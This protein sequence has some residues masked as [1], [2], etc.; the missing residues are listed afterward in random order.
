MMSDTVSKLSSLCGQARAD[1]LDFVRTLV[2]CDSPPGKESAAAALLESE[3]RRLN[4]DEVTKDEIGNVIGVIKGKSSSE[5]VLLTSHLDCYS[6][7]HDLSLSRDPASSAIDPGYSVGYAAC[8]AKA[9][10][11][12]QLYAGACLKRLLGV[13]SCSLAVCGCVAEMGGLGIGI[14]H[15]LST[16]LPAQGIYP[17]LAL[18]GNPTSLNIR[19]GHDGWIG[20][21]VQVDGNHLS[22]VRGVSL[23]LAK[24]LRKKAVQGTSAGRGE[25]L[26]VDSPQ[27]KEFTDL[28]RGTI[29]VERRL[30][31]ED[32][33]GQV[34]ADVK[35]YVR[36]VASNFGDIWSEVNIDQVRHELV[37]GK[38][39]TIPSIVQPW[40]SDDSDDR[41][42]LLTQSLQTA[43]CNFKT[44]HWDLHRLQ[45]GTS[46]SVLSGQ[47][48]ITC[49]GYGPG[50][51]SSLVGC[52]EEIPSWKMTAATFGNAVMLNAVVGPERDNR[53]SI[54]RKTAVLDP[55]SDTHR[56]GG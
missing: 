21:I 47:Y 22:Q 52:D 43:D 53:E 35:A 38:S 44:G 50:D 32:S 30:N 45:A 17:K 23:A 33:I 56:I 34:I 10:L 12:A 42:R 9:G 18:I 55:R 6:P 19:L 40:A 15:L 24:R 20:L 14:R 31:L 1:A 7:L 37:N 28:W 16:T 41:V 2:A 8:T 39:V 5:A 27:Y 25:T 49:V 29:R 54:N 13:P 51:E 48:G 3:M 4:Y 26:H 11:V 36:T 46:G